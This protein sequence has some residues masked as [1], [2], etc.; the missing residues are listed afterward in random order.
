MA[1]GILAYQAV[2]SKLKDKAS[3]LPESAP[4]HNVESFQSQYDSLISAAK[5]RY[6]LYNYIQNCLL[7]IDQ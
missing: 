4:K 1:Q 2:I 5:V 3:T 7:I 6:P